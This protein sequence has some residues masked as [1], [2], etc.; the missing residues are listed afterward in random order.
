[1]IPRSTAALFA[2]AALSLG[3]CATLVPYETAVERL[4]AGTFVELND[5][6]VHIQTAGSEASGLPIVLVHGFGASTFSWRH[7]MPALAQHHPVVAVDLVGFGLTQ[8]PRDKNRYTRTAQVELLSALLDHLG[9]PSA[10]FVGHSYGGGLVMSLAH[11]EPARVR[12]LILVGS[13]AP[14]YGD[15]RRSLLAVRPLASVFVRTYLRPR[16]IRRSLIRSFYDDKAVTDELVA[17]Y[18]ERVRIEGAVKAYV[19]LTAPAKPDARFADLS[20]EQLEQPVLVVWGAEDALIA[21]ADGR[22]AAEQMPRGSFVE[23][24]ECGHLPMEE[25]PERLLAEVLPFL[26]ALESPASMSIEMGSLS[27]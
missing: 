19:G 5:S 23:I 21:A 10:H 17:S 3:G 15:S 1:M 7:V 14:D 11:T 20:Y 26:E 9:W 8:R 16:F 12:S 22:T 24:D 4:P 25:Q 2:V 13:T 6:L 27:H 18:L